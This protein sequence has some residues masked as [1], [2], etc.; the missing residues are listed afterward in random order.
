M[1]QSTPLYEAG[2]PSTTRAFF[3]RA[4]TCPQ[5][6]ESQSVGLGQM[7]PLAGKS[8]DLTPNCSGTRRIRTIAN[9][10]AKAEL[11]KGLSDFADSVTRDESV[12]FSFLKSTSLFAFSE[13]PFKIN[14][15][16]SNYIQ[17]HSS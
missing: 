10:I 6:P 1:E 4:A 13:I 9:D 12:A 15:P 14:F 5:L 16:R 2:C 8:K 17:Q 11:Y 3:E 7:G